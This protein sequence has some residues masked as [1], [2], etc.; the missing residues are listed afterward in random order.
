MYPKYDSQWETLII[1]FEF[2]MLLEFNFSSPGPYKLHFKGNRYTKHS[3]L[4]H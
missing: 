2:E 3:S 4:S 1:Y